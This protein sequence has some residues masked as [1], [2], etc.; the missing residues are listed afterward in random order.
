[1]ISLKLNNY[2]KKDIE[3]LKR[4]LLQVMQD[5]GVSLCTKTL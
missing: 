4:Y 3:I 5:I 1:M 2:K